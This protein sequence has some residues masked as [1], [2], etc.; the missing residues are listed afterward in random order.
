MSFVRMDMSV[1]SNSNAHTIVVMHGDQTGEELLQEALR[2]LAPGVIGMDLDFPALRY[3]PGKIGCHAEC[4]G[5]GSGGGDA[6]NW[7]GIEGG[8]DYPIQLE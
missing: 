1:L 6:P 7:P 2:V 8:H 5:E 4:G 3:Q